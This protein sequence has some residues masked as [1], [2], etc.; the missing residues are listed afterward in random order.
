MKKEAGN[1]YQGLSIDG[2]GITVVA[3]QYTYEYDSKDNTYDA[4]AGKDTAFYTLAEFNALTEIP[5]V[6]R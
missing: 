2:I 6:S 5:R 1:E 3:T 4:D